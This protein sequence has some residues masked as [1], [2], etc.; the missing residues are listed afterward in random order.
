M[1]W[2]VT[3]LVFVALPLLAQVG[4]RQ[5][6]PKVQRPDGAVWD[7]IRK[8]CTDCHG[9]D[10]YAF[11]AQDRTAWQKLIADKHKSGEANL[12][13]TNLS[14]TDKTI[15]LDWLVSKF[16]PDTKPF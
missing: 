15:L 1:K 2:A 4:G 5:A 9:I 8:N 3:V 14:D 12:S 10:D 7:V 16:G 6:R 11:Y 13:D